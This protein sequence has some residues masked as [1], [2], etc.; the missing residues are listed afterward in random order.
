MRDPIDIYACSFDFK[1]KIKIKFTY[2][3]DIIMHTEDFTLYLQ[4]VDVPS[5]PG[6]ETEEDKNDKGWPSLKEKPFWPSLNFSLNFKKIKKKMNFMN[7]SGMLVSNVC[8]VALV[9]QYI[10]GGHVKL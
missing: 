6:Q 4:D 2:Y 7:N 9:A 5:C 3:I 10:D 1:T 8:L